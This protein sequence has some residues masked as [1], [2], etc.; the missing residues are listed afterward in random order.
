MVWDARR[1]ATAA[2]LAGA[3]GVIWLAASNADAPPGE[4]PPS[5]TASPAEQPIGPEARSA[6]SPPPERP[7]DSVSSV[8]LGLDF[9]RPAEVAR[10]Y[11]VAAHSLR[12]T[13]RG[14]TN[15]RVLP[16][17]APDNP[18]NP[19]GLVV[20][21]PPPAGQA[22]TAT[23]DRL[24]VVG[25]DQARQRIAYEAQWSAPAIDRR[26]TFVVLARQPDGRWL[27]TQESTRLQPGD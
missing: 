11:L 25:S 3:L 4:T 20:V 15:R 8:P 1:I 26:T 6:A 27:V 23:V 9:R 17:L 19:R 18:A 21:D 12:G 5:S 7:G 13:D 2:A 10:A 22:T 14:R 24:R 16:Y